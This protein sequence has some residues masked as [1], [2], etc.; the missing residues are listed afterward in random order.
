MTPTGYQGVRRL[1]REKPDWIP[2]VRAALKCVTTT[3]NTGTEDNEVAGT[4]VLEELNRSD[5]PGM[6]WGDDTARWFP[7]LRTLVGYGILEHRDT[8]RGGR[9][10]YYSMPDPAGV[11]R[12]LRDLGE[13]K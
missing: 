5:W 7:G 4:W 3:Y 11:E 8:V 10:A 9:R 13:L 2:V 1:A 12:A 6:K